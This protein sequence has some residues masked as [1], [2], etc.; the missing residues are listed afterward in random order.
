[1]RNPAETLLILTPEEREAS[2]RF[3]ERRLCALD[4]ERLPE[5]QDLV[6]TAR[7]QV[8]LIQ[9][10]KDR[11]RTTTSRSGRLMATLYDSALAGLT[12]L[13]TKSAR[14][15]MVVERDLEE[16]QSADDAQQ[17]QDGLDTEAEALL[18]PCS[19]EEEA[20]AL[21]YIRSKTLE[22]N[23]QDLKQIRD[24]TRDLMTWWDSERG[25]MESLLFHQF[26]N[27]NSASG[28][29]AIRQKR[30]GLRQKVFNPFRA[31][32]QELNLYYQKMNK[33]AAEATLQE[34]TGDELAE[35][36]D[37]DAIDALIEGVQED[38]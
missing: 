20:H 38:P 13:I 15:A 34:K 35:A 27:L 26:G 11:Y 18:L 37:D 8:K 16:R 14:A 1:M 2:R 28:R 21:D 19:A 4:A 36:I 5:L 17:S 30:E 33:G 32:F 25:Q 29:A 22:L 10:G 31:F 24:A 9:R 12:D 7:Q 6:G 3:I 23:V